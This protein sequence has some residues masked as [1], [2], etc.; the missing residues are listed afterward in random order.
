MGEWRCSFNLIYLDTRSRWMVSFTP[1]SLNPRLIELSIHN[2]VG[3]WVV[4]RAGLDSVKNRRNLA[5][6]G[7]R[8]TAVQASSSSLHQ[9]SYAD[10]LW[11]HIQHISKIFLCSVGYAFSWWSVV[12]E[13]RKGNHVRILTLNLLHLMGLS[14]H[15]LSIVIYMMGWGAW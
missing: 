1:R 9:L 4:P 2:W 13:T 10:P 14:T 5:A 7:I 15:A 11:Q 12:A 6:A 8:T 3:G